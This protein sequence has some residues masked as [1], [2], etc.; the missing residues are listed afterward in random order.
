MEILGVIDAKWVGYGSVAFNADTDTWEVTSNAVC[1][2][3]HDVGSVRFWGGEFGSDV[4]A[5]DVLALST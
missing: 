2:E 4:G 3:T 1:S 5:W